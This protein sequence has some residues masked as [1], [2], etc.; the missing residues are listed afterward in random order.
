MRY[1][2]KKGLK[3]VFYAL[4]RLHIKYF[5]LLIELF[6][7]FSFLTAHIIIMVFNKKNEFFIVKNK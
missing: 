5:Y 2:K 3:K 1:I 7:L 4:N 6:F